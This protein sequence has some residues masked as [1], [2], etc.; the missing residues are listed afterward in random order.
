MVTL[1]AYTG[2]ID[3]PTHCWS[4]STR[5]AYETTRKIGLSALGA[6]IAIDLSLPS[7]ARAGSRSRHSRG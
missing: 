7:N 1:G 2:Y 4:A 3:D 5:Q 6:D